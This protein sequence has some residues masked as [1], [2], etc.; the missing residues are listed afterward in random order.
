M[1]GEVILSEKDRE[2]QRLK[3]QI[4]N[5]DENM[6][7]LLMVTKMT[8]EATEATKSKHIQDMDKIKKRQIEY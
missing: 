5:M 7:Q 3:M 1:Q 2:V 8:T 6:R 4:K